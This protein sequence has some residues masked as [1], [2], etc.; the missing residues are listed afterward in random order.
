MQ[1]EDKL[2]QYLEAS[3]CFRRV[4]IVLVDESANFDCGPSGREQNGT[5]VL[6]G[7]EVYARGRSITPLAETSSLELCFQTDDNEASH[8]MLE[9][10]TPGNV[11]RVES[12][13]WSM[14][15]GE[16]TFYLENLASVVRVPDGIAQSYRSMLGSC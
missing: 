10:F 5:I 6:G 9:I 16:C 4:V 2:Y 15:D 12:N 1:A 13:S 11:L 7:Y 3:G 14:C 8:A